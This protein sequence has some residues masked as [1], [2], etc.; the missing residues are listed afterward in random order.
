MI[1]NITIVTAFFDI[2][3]E[4]WSVENG[5]PDYLYR[6]SYTYIE[7]FKNLSI[8]ENELIVFTSREFVDI[9]KEIRGNKP[10]KIVEFD[11]LSE[12]KVYKNRIKKIQNSLEFQSKISPKQIINPE[13]WS[14]DYT[15]LTNLKTYFV[16]RAISLDLVSNSTLAWLDFGYCRDI[17]MLNGITEWKYNFSDDKIHTFSLKKIPSLD[18]KKVT[19]SIY[20]NKVFI[21]GGVTIGHR[22][23]WKEFHRLVYKCQIDLLRKGIVDDDQGIYLYAYYKDKE[24]FK[25]HVLGKN[26]WRVIFKV[27]DEKANLSFKNKIKKFFKI[28]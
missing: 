18:F 6:T 3:R 26:N 4:N 24:L 16:N 13:Y 12:F 15:L 11:Y 23:C 7:F 17:E 21:I 9:V 10:T 27:Y 5:Y 19:D 1:T 28:L 20:N 14:S 25:N 2:G 22:D 8:L